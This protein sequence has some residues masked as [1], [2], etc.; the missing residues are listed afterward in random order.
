M[1]VLKRQKQVIALSP[2]QVN[3]FKIAVARSELRSYTREGQGV[4]S[5]GHYI[6]NC[7]KKP[8]MSQGDAAGA[9]PISLFCLG[10]SGSACVC[11][12]GVE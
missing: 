3:A 2:S 10:L 9:K 11:C 7:C 4:R 6:T 5:I 12:A 8:V 1:V